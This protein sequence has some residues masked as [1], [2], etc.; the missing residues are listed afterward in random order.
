M[1]G[2]RF[3]EEACTA[4]RVAERLGEGGQ[5]PRTSLRL[6]RLRSRKQELDRRHVGLGDARTIDLEGFLPAE[7]LSYQV[8]DTADRRN[9]AIDREP[10]RILGIH[11]SS[12]HHPTGI[13]TNSV[14][15]GRIPRANPLRLKC[16]RKA[17]LNC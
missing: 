14:P 2:H 8:I 9:T 13:L 6:A 1:S 3:V 4:K 15:S 7:G 11:F 16:D 12:L 5:N 17:Y 10:Q